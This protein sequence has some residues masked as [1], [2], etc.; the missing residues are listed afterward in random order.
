M[1]DEDIIAHLDSL[2][3]DDMVEKVIVPLYRK[4]FKTFKKVE[5]SGK[6]KREDDGIDI[7]YYEIGRETN[8]KE[9][10]G[11]QVKQGTI[12]TSKGAN[13]IAAISIQA[14]QAFN[15]P[16]AN[17]EDKKNFKIQGYTVLTTGDIQP[18]ARAQIVD[19][20]EHKTIRFV[21]GKTLCDW[22]R[23]S[24]LTEFTELFGTPEATD[25]DDGEEPL[26][27]ILEYLHKKCRKA[28]SE[29]EAIY[30]VVDGSQQGILKAL[31]ILGNSKA[32][33]IA[34]FVQRKVYH[35]EPDLD[36]MI[37]EDLLSADEDGYWL[38]EFG[39]AW[40]RIRSEAESR[41]ELLGYGD[42]IEISDVVEGLF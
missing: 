3:E 29:I 27:A 12:N 38:N 17:V 8:S 19:Q 39:S 26:D 4:R 22:I 21:D 11:V 6:D 24:W 23:D 7:T 34:A 15:K 2:S 32:V 30:S 18:K 13:G 28:I 14:Q 35:I 36:V 9:Y 10:G 40:D 25:D 1:K 37:R 20:F 16:I 41:I 31:M 5:F 33:K 42:E